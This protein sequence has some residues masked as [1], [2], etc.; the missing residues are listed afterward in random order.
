MTIWSIKE[1]VIQ[2]K[3]VAANTDLGQSYNLSGGNR[4]PALHDFRISQEQGFDGDLH[5]T[6]VTACHDVNQAFIFL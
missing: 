4:V 6:G 5:M 1:F 2:L 3:P